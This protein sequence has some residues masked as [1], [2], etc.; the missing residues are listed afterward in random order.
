MSISPSSTTP[1]TYS[2][3]PDGFIRLLRLIP[4]QDANATI[5]C[6]IF[7]YPLQGTAH[8]THL[9][10]AL[11]YVWGTPKNPQPVQILP[12]DGSGGNSC[13]FLVTPNLHSALLHLRDR[14]LERVIW[15]DAVCI[16]QNDNDEK[17]RQVVLMTKI[18]DSANR[19]V[20]FLGDADSNSDQALETI[21]KAAEEQSTRSS[22]G[23]NSPLQPISSNPVTNVNKESVFSLFKR[24]WFQRTW[25]RI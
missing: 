13:Q 15:I 4:H 22:L 24:A 25:V 18:Y 1:Y 2:P 19:V 9:Y 10:E 6:R 20:V 21:R 8:G 14:Y 16:N 7:H 5:Q 12:E 3:L 11:S 17:A 23:E